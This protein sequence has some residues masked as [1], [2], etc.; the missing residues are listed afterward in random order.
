MT[1][2]NVYKKIRKNSSVDIFIKLS[3][4]DENGCSSDVYIKD[5]KEKNLTDKEKDF[6]VLHGNKWGRQVAKHFNVTY[7]RIGG[8]NTKIIGWKCEG[9]NVE[10]NGT[11]MIRKDIRDYFS[12]KPCV[13]TGLPNRDHKKHEID[14][15]NGR[16]DDKLVLNLE[17]QTLN[18]FQP[19]C[20][21]ANLFKRSECEKC[22]ATNCRFDAQKLGYGVSFTKGNHNYDSC[23]GCYWFDPLD[24][25]SKLS[26]V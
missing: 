5:I 18:Q 11:R 15:K 9:F 6:L 10:D 13:H 12:N 25:K 8:K 19:L 21:E 4:I 16:Y 20:R 17:S 24:F 7:H 2:D 3:Q 22:E 1:L 26:L 14:H 23:E